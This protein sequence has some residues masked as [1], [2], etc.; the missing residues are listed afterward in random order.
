M[1]QKSG[2]T[3]SRNPLMRS[4]WSRMPASPSGGEMRGHLAPD[5]PHL[6]R[7]IRARTRGVEPDLIAHRAAQQAVH[8]LPEDLAEQVPQGQVGA[9][10]R[11]DDDPAA[12]RVEVRRIDHLV[13]NQPDVVDAA[14][15]E[16]PGEVLL[17][18]EASDQ[19][20]RR[21]GESRRTVVGLHLDH[22]GAEHIDAE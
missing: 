2:P 9:R 22:E 15:D 20:G 8:R 5:E 17:D 1:S 10:D 3:T 4:A 13:M 7:E 12:A 16:E 21:D 11:V 19:T 14:P 18:D 6:L